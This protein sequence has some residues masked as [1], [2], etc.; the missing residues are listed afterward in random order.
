MSH[1]IND[2]INNLELVRVLLVFVAY[3]QDGIQGVES[4][5][6][7]YIA[8]MLT[9]ICNGVSKIIE[10]IREHKHNSLRLIGLTVNPARVHITCMQRSQFYRSRV[11]VYVW[12]CITSNISVVVYGNWC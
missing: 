3:I 12:N 10:G 8:A 7:N 6:I 5:I 1:A 2:N 11:H 4:Y 9:Y